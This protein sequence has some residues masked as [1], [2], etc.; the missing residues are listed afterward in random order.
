MNKRMEYITNNTE[1]IL[2]TGAGYTANFGGFLAK[3]MYQKIFNHNELLACQKVKDL[4][5]NE[6]N[7]FDYEYIYFSVQKGDYKKEEKDAINKAI[8]DI[9]EKLDS[10]VRNWKYITTSRYPTNI[11]KVNSLIIDLI[12]MH[13]K[14]GFFFTLNQ[15][16]FFE[17]HLP[18]R[19]FEIPFFEQER[20][21]FR[22]NRNKPIKKVIVPTKENIESNKDKILKRNAFY[23]KLHGS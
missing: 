18:D 12:A 3:D 10:I 22:V 21:R 14:F 23:V 4:M 19:Y 1:K 5:R 11:Y 15:D 9:Y 13:N 17:R 7:E 16:L 8:L 2:F 20:H 6:K